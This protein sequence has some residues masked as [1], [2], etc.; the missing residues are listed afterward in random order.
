[1]KRV[2]CWLGF[3]S[4]EPFE[5]EW[6]GLRGAWQKWLR[7]RTFKECRRCKR[8]VLLPASPAGGKTP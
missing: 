4:W 1:M 8:G 7:N 2:L 6:M 3:H 5:V